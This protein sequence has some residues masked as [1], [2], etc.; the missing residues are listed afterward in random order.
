MFVTETLDVDDSAAVLLFGEDK[1]SGETRL[2]IVNEGTDTVYVGGD[3]TVDD[4]DMPVPATATLELFPARR[5]DILW[6]ICAAGK[7]ATLKLLYG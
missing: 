3:D 5:Q 4:T 1:G 6:G 2:V 7:T